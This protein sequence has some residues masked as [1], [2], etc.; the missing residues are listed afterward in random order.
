MAGKT[1]CQMLNGSL[2]TT[3]VNKSIG[4]MEIICAFAGDEAECPGGV[5]PDLRRA[6]GGVHQ[7]ARGSL[8]QPG[9]P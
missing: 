5:Q 4:Y 9:P 8:L 6:G 3:R 2:K 7:D 1:G